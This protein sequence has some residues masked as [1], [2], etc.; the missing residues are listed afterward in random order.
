MKHYNVFISMPMRGLP[1]EEVLAAQEQYKKIMLNHLTE[2]AA[3]VTFLQ[4][5][6]ADTDEATKTPLKCFAKSVVILAEADILVLAGDWENARGC[7]LEKEIAKYYGLPIAVI[8]G[9][10]LYS[11]DDYLVLKDG[12]LH[13]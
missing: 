4:N 13:F 12:E 10:Y 7:W 6:L 3:A 8:M 1:T 2:G 5:V 11:Y 9:D